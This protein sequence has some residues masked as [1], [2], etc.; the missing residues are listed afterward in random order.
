MAK[1]LVQ[2]SAEQPSVLALK[3]PSNSSGVTPMEASPLERK[4]VAILAA[5]VEGYSRLMHADEELTLATLTSHRAIIDELIGACRGEP[6]FWPSLRA[7]SMRS[8]VPLA[9]SRL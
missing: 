8:I 1:A 9:F 3:Q 7:S 2:S 4:L 5:D 6:V